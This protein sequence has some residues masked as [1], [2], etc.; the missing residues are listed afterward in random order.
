MLVFNTAFCCIVF[1]TLL[2]CC[3]VFNTLFCCTVF[4]THSSSVQSLLLLTL[5]GGGGGGAT[6]RQTRA[7]RESAYADQ[8]EKESARERERA[9]VH[10]RKRGYERDRENMHAKK[11]RQCV[12][13]RKRERDF[14][15]QHRASGKHLKHLK[16]LLHLF[17]ECYQRLHSLTVFGASL[18]N[19]WRLSHVTHFCQALRVCFPKMKKNEKNEKSETEWLLAFEQSSKHRTSCKH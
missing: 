15:C 14:W 19:H 17:A 8:R 13:A 12:F 1:N 11:K 6:D 4:N 16:T 10:I 2:F 3:R 7:W 5:R 18:P 9:V